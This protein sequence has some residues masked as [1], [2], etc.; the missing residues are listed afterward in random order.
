MTKSA[1]ATN[2]II[3]S[4]LSS[5]DDV[6]EFVLPS[7]KAGDGDG[8]DRQAVEKVAREQER[9]GETGVV[10]LRESLVHEDKGGGE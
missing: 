2:E 1:Y 7:P 10:V 9:E 8:E 6:E 5:W 3:S 4:F